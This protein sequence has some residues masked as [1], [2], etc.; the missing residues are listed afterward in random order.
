MAVLRNALMA[1]IHLRA[2]VPTAGKVAA[3]TP[4][5]PMS[6]SVRASRAAENLLARTNLPSIV[7]NVQPDGLAAERTQYAVT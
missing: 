5:V 1:T 2:T 3:P 6:M 7:A 4:F